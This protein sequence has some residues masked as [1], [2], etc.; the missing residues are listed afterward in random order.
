MKSVEF[1]TYKHQILFYILTL[2]GFKPFTIN[3]K[4]KRLDYR[5]IILTIFYII[6]GTFLIGFLNFIPYNFSNTFYILLVILGFIL[7]LL[8]ILNIYLNQ[9]YMNSIQ[10]ENITPL[11]PLI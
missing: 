1:L 7:I 11:S 5:N 4:G 8:P 9:I 2:F 10:I 3:I 6:V